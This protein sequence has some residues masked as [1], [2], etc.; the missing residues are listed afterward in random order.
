MFIGADNLLE[1][2]GDEVGTVWHSVRNLMNMVDG[3]VVISLKYDLIDYIETKYP[4]I[5]TGYLAFASFGDTAALNCDYLALEEEVASEDTINSI[6]YK[7]KKVLVWTVNDDDDIENYLQNGADAL[8]TDNVSGAKN[9]T[10]ALNN[11]PT[12][13]RIVNGLFRLFNNITQK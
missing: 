12:M 1:L 13:D 6:H 10:E 4:E 7:G 8:I 11:A 5:N 2:L 9:F 3:A